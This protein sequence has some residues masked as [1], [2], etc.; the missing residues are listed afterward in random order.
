M[1][2][3]EAVAWA[4]QLVYGGY[5]DWRLPSTVDGIWELGYDGTTKYTKGKL[6]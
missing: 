4:D 6:D 3:P 5:N 2:W 1:Y